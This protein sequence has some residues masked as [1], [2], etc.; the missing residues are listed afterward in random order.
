MT[1]KEIEHDKGKLLSAVLSALPGK[2]LAIWAKVRQEVPSV[3]PSEVWRCLAN[4]DDIALD[5][6][7]GIWARRG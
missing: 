5:L 2:H 4:C 3:G 1:V 6:K 7:T